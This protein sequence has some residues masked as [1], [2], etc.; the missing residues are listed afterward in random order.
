MSAK[1]SKGSSQPYHD[2]SK[3]RTKNSKIKSSNLICKYCN[4]VY[5]EK[6]W[7]AFDKLNFRDIDKL[8]QSV[9]PACH[10]KKNHVSDG[11]LQLSG[12]F[13]RNHLTEISGIIT[14]TAATELKR[15]VLNRIERLDLYPTLVTVYTSKNQLAVEIGKRVNSAYK[16]GKLDIKWSKKD[17]PVSV[18][19][20]K[21]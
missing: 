3:G 9:C 19:W 13:L 2:P 21:D 7:Q 15:D 6:H 14:N 5:G 10:E 17:K 11:V 16:G 1:K 20:H 4:A 18:K 12:K 8:K